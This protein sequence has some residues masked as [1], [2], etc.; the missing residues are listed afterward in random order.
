[1]YDLH[2]ETG[3][4][5]VINRFGTRSLK[6]WAQKKKLKPDGTEEP[7]IKL[8]K[9]HVMIAN[10]TKVCITGHTRRHLPTLQSPS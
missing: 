5:H 4:G 3:P 1:V 6:N 8:P 9:M 10:R 7:L 2:D